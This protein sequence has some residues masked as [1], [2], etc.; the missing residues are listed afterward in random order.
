MSNC[1]QEFGPGLEDGELEA[2][3]YAELADKAAAIAADTRYDIM[4]SVRGILGDLAAA[5]KRTLAALEE[6][7]EDRDQAVTAIAMVTSGG[8]RS[9]DDA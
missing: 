3:E 7:E 2:K 6:V 8:P 1:E 5:M 9:G 4:P